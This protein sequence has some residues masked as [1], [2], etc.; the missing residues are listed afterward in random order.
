MWPN[1]QETSDLVAFTEEILNGKLHFLCSGYFLSITGQ[2]C[3]NTHISTGHKGLMC[4]ISIGRCC[5][6][7]LWPNCED[8]M[9]RIKYFGG[10]VL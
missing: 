2:A 10:T 8:I 4:H 3:L 9:G 7:K 6:T 1:P 5:E